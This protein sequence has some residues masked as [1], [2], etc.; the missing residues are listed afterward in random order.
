MAVG[1]AFAV[2]MDRFET[3]Y[4]AFD[5]LLT[6]SQTVPTVAIAPLFV[7][8][9]GYGLL[10]KVLLVVITTFFP[11]TVAL[12]NGFRSVDQD[13]IDLMRTMRATEWQIFRY[14]KLPAAMDQFFSGLRISATYAIVGAV[15][16]EWLGGFWGLGVYMTRVRK[17][18]SYDR[19]FAVIIIISALSLA[20]MRG[21]DVLER[22]CMPW[23]RAERN[24]QQ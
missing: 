15:I 17:S 22:I 13:Q 11:V 16:S 14:A 4:L 7:L 6:V 3:F 2:L 23:K 20:L 12:A 24:D 10:P 8:W 1:F 9:F 5:P 21:V 18:F 19:M